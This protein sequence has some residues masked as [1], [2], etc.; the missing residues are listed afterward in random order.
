MS[1]LENERPCP[2][3]IALPN[4]RIHPETA[5]EIA[6]SVYKCLDLYLWLGNHFPHCFLQRDEAIKK[7]LECTRIVARS[8]EQ[9]TFT[10]KSERR[11]RERLRSDHGSLV[12]EPSVDLEQLDQILNDLRST[13]YKK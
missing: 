4:R 11:A 7:R 1:Q 12:E 9:I 8:L 6:E 5:L 13:I 10:P 3:K 2:V